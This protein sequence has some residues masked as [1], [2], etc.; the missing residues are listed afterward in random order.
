M[1]VNVGVQLQDSAMSLSMLKRRNNKSHQD[2]K[3]AKS[4]PVVAMIEVKFEQKYEPNGEP[5]DQ[6]G[7]DVCNALNQLV[8]KC[9]S[10][11]ERSNKASC[12]VL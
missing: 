2:A 12:D 1:E 6:L 9:V 3:R 8:D 10:G 7:C 4:E 5:K 11:V